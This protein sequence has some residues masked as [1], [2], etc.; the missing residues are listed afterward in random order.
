[1][2]V[3]LQLPALLIA[4]CS[5]LGS[6]APDYAIGTY[7]G[8]VIGRGT[9]TS[10]AAELTVS[11]AKASASGDWYIE[12]QNIRAQFVAG[13]VYSAGFLA[14]HRASQGGME[15]VS[16]YFTPDGAALDARIETGTCTNTG[17]LLRA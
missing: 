10:A 15:Y 12:Q 13:W 8:A 5:G 2:K 6:V 9:C 7:R 11:I 17:S 4:G 3:V 14:S 16:G 1:M